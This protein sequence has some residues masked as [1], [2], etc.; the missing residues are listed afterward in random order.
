[1]FMIHVY[2]YIYIYIGHCTLPAI[3]GILRRSGVEDDEA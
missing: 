1:M 3:A 2:I